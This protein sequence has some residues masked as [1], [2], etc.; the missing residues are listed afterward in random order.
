VLSKFILQSVTVRFV[1]FAQIRFKG[2]CESKLD[3][4]FREMIDISKIESGPRGNVMQY[5][6]AGSGTWRLGPLSTCSF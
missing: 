6:E 5:M 4:R 3:E 2:N 1:V